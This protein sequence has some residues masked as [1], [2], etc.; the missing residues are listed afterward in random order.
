MESE[1]VAA[2]VAVTKSYRMDA[3]TVPVLHGVELAIRPAMFTV[4]LG[5]SG[6]GKTTMLNL[7]GCLDRPDQGQ[8]RVAGT[9][10]GSLS[11][12]ELTDFRRRNIGFVFQSFNLIPVLTAFE[13]IE[14]PLVLAGMDRTRRERRVRRLLEAVGLEARA[15]NRPGQLSGGQ[16]QRVAIA[17]ALA[18]K[19]RIVIADEPTANLDSRTGAAIIALMR[20]MQINFKISFIFSSHDSGLIKSADDL[21]MLRDGR[22]RSVHHKGVAVPTPVAAPDSAHPAESEPPDAPDDDIGARLLQDTDFVPADEE[23][24][25]PP[26]RRP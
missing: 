6:S 21:V 7:L 8:V 10:V 23:A 15:Q 26:P 1:P 2:L 20:W 19:P 14:Y 4:V 3:V 16:R 24:A 17:R 25:S 11:D 9:D 13:N 12:D 22:I 18:H 5:P